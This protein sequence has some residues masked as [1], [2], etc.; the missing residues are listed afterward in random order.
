[1]QETPE[2]TRRRRRIVMWIGLGAVLILG[3]AIFLGW[4]WL[5]TFTQPEEAREMIAEAGAWAPLVF[6]GL[7]VIQVLIAP[8]PGQVT[9]L[10]G[11]LLFGT[12]WGVVYTM[13]GATI[14]FTL[15][16]VLARRLG[17]PFVE[18]FV[19]PNVL[20]R[21]DYLSER[22][23]AFVLFIIFLL[24][25]FPDDVISFIAGLTTLRISTLIFISL[26]GRLPGYIVLS[27]TGA[28]LAYENMNPIV[29]SIGVVLVIF[30]IGFWKR[31]FL[32]EMVESGDMTGFIRERWTLSRTKSILLLVG[33]IV[34][35]V[36]LYMLATVEPIPNLETP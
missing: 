30:A 20:T 33:I 21:F 3:L 4:P 10:V 11:G 17:R 28:G 36:L 12:L 32:Q 9:G 34:L 35:G 2:L 31:S 7:Q 22:G 8:I 16:F 14:G 13:I 18:R 23:G 1:M 26:A 19:S 29:V 5:A 24:P 6:I 25:A 15:I 27:A